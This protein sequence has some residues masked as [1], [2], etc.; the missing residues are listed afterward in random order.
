MTTPDRPFA[1]SPDKIRQLVATTTG[2]FAT[3]RITRDGRPVGVM[4][5]ESPDWDGDSGWRFLAGDESEEYLADAANIRIYQ[6]NTIANFCP[7][8]I[9][10]LGLPIGTWLSRDDDGVL[11]VDSGEA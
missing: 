1:L 3:D 5:R 7:D 11:V 4:Y 10:H 2:C 9:P 8:I 6:V